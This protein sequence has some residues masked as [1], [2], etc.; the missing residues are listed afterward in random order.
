[1][2]KCSKTRAWL[3]L[4]DSEV[5]EIDGRRRAEV[6]VHLRECPTC[7]E[8]RAELNRVREVVARSGEVSLSEQYLED[9]T[10]RLSR[11][12]EPKKESGWGFLAWCRQL[13]ASPLPTSAQA[14]AVVWLALIL[15]L[16]FPG[17]EPALRQVLSVWG[18][19]L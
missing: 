5:E 1:M 14:V 8:Y 16:Q 6:E 2:S 19:L 11:V 7:F 18:R 10:A 12:L 3:P 15:A 4:A 17:V 9:F 13:E